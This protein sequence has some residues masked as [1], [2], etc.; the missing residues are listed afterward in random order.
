MNNRWQFLDT[1]PCMMETGHEKRII[2]AV[3]ATAVL[4]PKISTNDSLAPASEKDD[5]TF[6]QLLFG[7]VLIRHFV[8]HEWL[9]WH[10]MKVLPVCA[11][12]VIHGHI[13][14]VTV[15]QD[16]SKLLLAVA[17]AKAGSGLLISHH[18]PQ[19]PEISATLRD[20]LRI[21]RVLSRYLCPYMGVS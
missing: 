20:L 9:E 15:C 3:S 19:R 7:R 6:K 12:V 18:G 8:F 5:V 1:L 17:K 2:S 4:Q 13:P 10:C 11:F 21:T 16:A 14:P